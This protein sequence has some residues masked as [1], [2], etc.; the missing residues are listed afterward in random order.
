VN[1]SIVSAPSLAAEVA[2]LTAEVA[3]LTAEVAQLTAEVA[4]LSRNR[5]RGSVACG[6]IYLTAQLEAQR[7]L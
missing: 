5:E 2:E 4:Q 1:R 6:L 3:Q 7:V